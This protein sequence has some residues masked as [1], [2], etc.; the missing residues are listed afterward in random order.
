MSY[1]SSAQL[2]EGWKKS[3]SVSFLPAA[4]VLSGP[5]ADAVAAAEEAAAAVDGA[6]PDDRLPD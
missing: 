1:R 3:V 6:G 2:L 5:P 4:A